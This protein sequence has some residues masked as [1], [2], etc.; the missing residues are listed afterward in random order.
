MNPI[1]DK[2][3]IKRMV[4][5]NQRQKLGDIFHFAPVFHFEGKNFIDWRCVPQ[6]LLDILGAPKIASSFLEPVPVNTIR[7]K[8]ATPFPQS[9]SRL[10][11]LYE[12]QSSICY[13]CEKLIQWSRWTID[14]KLPTFRG[15]SNAFSNLVGTC[16]DC[17]NIKSCLTDTEFLAIQPKTAGIKERAAAKVWPMLHPNT[18]TH[19]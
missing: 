13:Y 15:G 1:P 12:N 2:Q 3:E 17:N 14:H 5:S 18:P 4:N 16:W 11:T 9:K 6:V 19:P 8:T 10:Q 7:K